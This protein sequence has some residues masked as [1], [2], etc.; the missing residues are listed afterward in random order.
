[1]WRVNPATSP[2]EWLERRRPALAPTTAY[3][4]EWALT[5]YLLPFFADHRLNDITPQE[6][7]R[8]IARAAAAGNLSNNTI[9]KTLVRLSMVLADAVE[10]GLIPSN[11][12]TGRRRRLKGTKPQRSWVE[13]EQLLALLDACGPWHRPVVATL[14]GAGLRIGEACALDWADVNIPTGTIT[15]RE[16]RPMPEQAGGSS[17]RLARPMSFGPGARGAPAPAGMIPCS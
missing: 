11:P 17:C 6:I 16:S 4:Y 1:M 5:H 15:V 12:A 14:A 13:P 3:D 7:D 8:D 2:R 9:N 10:Y